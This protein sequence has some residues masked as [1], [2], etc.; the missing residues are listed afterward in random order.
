MPLAIDSLGTAGFFDGVAAAGDDRHG[1]IILDRL[2]HGL[3]VVGLV[4]GDSQGRLRRL[5]KLTDDLIVMH[6]AAGHD[7][8]KRPALA[9]DERMDFG[10][11]AA[12]ADADCLMAFPPFAPAAARC[13]LTIVLSIICKLS[14]DL[15]ARAAKIGPR[16][17]APTTD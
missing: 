7:E 17:R 3:A 10:R 9:I 16:Y 6:L 15:A 14:R 13:A 1:T 5:Q 12:A 4:A 2:A 8:V 11:A